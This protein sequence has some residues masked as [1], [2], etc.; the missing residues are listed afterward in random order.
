VFNSGKN[1]NSTHGSKDAIMRES[2]I[3]SA[4]GKIQHA[5]YLGRG[6]RSRFDPRKAD[7]TEKE[8]HY[9]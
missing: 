5:P 9:Q 7:V 6:S 1:A 8:H 3:N 4:T 2:E